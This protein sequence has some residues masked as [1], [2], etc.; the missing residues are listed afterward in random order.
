MIEAGQHLIG[1]HDYRNFCKIDKDN[2]TTTR[3]IFSVD[4]VSANQS[5]YDVC[6]MV[7]IGQ[8]F[9][10]H[11]IRCIVAL[12]LTIGKGLEETDVIKKLLDIEK[13]PK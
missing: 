4:I 11:Q 1:E 9:L 3:K 10:W 5:N 8:S 7:I 6:E 13:Y 12:L 2:P